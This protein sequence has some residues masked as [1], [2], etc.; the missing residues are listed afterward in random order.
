[1]KTGVDKAREYAALVRSRLGD[2]VKQ[3]VLF[4]S[5][6]RGDGTEYSDY[7]FLV[8]VDTR[9]QSVRDAIL[10]V[11]VQMLNNHDQLFAALVYSEEE[12]RELR[13]FPLGWNIQ[14]ESARSL[15]DTEDDKYRCKGI[16][17]GLGISG[18]R[19]TGMSA[20]EPT[21]HVLGAMLAKADERLSTAQRDLAASAFG[22]AASRAY[23]SVFHAISA[24]LATRG[25]TFSS[26]SQN[27]RCV[28]S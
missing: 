6:A 8:V 5:Q 12:W 23:Y 15:R 7:D 11:G 10:D 27:Y 20:F 21:G 4:G 16:A 1:M 3:I 18:S 9:T 24:L 2:H 19:Y 25:L 28:Q 22:D 26:H 14:E 17:R 13:R